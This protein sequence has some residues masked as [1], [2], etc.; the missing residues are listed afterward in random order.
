MSVGQVGYIPKTENLPIRQFLV[1]T[2][3][4]FCV[5]SCDTSDTH[6]MWIIKIWGKK[7]KGSTYD[8][9]TS[10]PDENQRKG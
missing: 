3:P 1:S 2:A 9:Q 6:L 4:W 8:R 5:L 10:A 7:T